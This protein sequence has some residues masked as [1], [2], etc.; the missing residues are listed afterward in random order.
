M[1][2]LIEARTR[3]RPQG[4]QMAGLADRFSDFCKSVKRTL[5]VE[6]SLNTKPKLAAENL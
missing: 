1:L 5:L 3:R 2:P 6:R 4:V